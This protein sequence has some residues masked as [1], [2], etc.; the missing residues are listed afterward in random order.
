[1][2]SLNG[3]M[4]GRRSGL[5][6]LL[7]V[8]L[9]A[10]SQEPSASPAA[11]S[12]PAPAS[13]ASVSPT[14]ANLAPASQAPAILSVDEK[15]ARFAARQSVPLP[16]GLPK[17]WRAALEPLAAKYI[18][19]RIAQQT[20]IDGAPPALAIELVFRL[21]GDDA[22]L[23]AAVKEA[24]APWPAA[25]IEIDR[26]KGVAPRQSQYTVR[27]KRTPAPPAELKD[28]RAP[29]AIGLPAEAPR[30]L[31]RFTHARSNRRR[32]AVEVEHTAQATTVHLIMLYRGGYARDEA[33]RH[34]QR[35]AKAARFAAEDGLDGVWRHANGQT[36]RWVRDAADLQVGCRIASP[37]LRFS[38]V[39][40]RG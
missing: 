28:C 6:M 3:L 15:R 1:M 7:G 38:W 9:W 2:N 17:R 32:V 40:P 36:V 24:L 30:W 23:D 34:F 22:A 37:V 35:F 11:G 8:G 4:P 20:R 26:V 27:F 10:C 31:D 33:M 12:S 39:A 16:K 5:A 19:T 18:S 21:F 25:Q 14:S 13:Q 29:K